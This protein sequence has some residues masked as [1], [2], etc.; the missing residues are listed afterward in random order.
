LPDHLFIAEKP[1]LAE[2]I[3]KA[4]AEQI[5]AT[6]TKT[7]GC[8]KVGDDA[9]T[10]LFGHM[11]ELAQP[12]EY[13][14]RYKTWRIDDLPIIPTKWRRTP[15][16]DKAKHLAFIRNMLKS[17]QFVVN[18]GDAE[19]EGQL[20]VDELLEEM[21]WDPF[22]DRTKRIW[23]SSMARK[24]MLAALES[25]F[26]N[27][28]KRNL[29]QAAF[30][31]QC[32]DW[33]HGLSLTRLYTVL[34]RQ[35]GADMLVTVGRVQ[36]PTLWLVV[37]RDRQIE[38]FKPTDHY[39]PN[40]LFRH[41]NGTFKAD[42]VIPP[43]HE[44]LDPDGRLVDK[45]VAERIAAKVAG[46][47]GRI[48]SFTSTPKSKAPPLPYSLSALQTDCS[49]KL[50]LTAQ[51]TL[52]VAQS[53]YERHR[54]TTYPRSDSRYLP[55]ALRDEVPGIMS[56][57]AGCDGFGE[58]ARKAN[59]SLKSAAW[60][61]SKVSD[62]HGIIPTSEFSPSK[63]AEM[64]QIERSVFEL[65]AKA[66]I[67][68]FHPDFT[69]KSLVATLTV[70]GETFRATGRQVI[71][72]GWK[73][74]YGAEE[75]DEDEDKET[76]QTLPQMAKGD[77]VV[78]ESTAIASKRTQPPAH[79]T[80]GSL[81]AAMA[82]IHKFVP[83]GEIKRR[84]KE[85]DGIGTEATRASIIEKLVAMKFL[86][87]KGKTK[88]VST[89]AGRAIIDVLPRE[90][91]DP[92]LT[93]IWEAQLTKISK[94]E[95]STDQ[96]MEVLSRTLH[97]LVEQGRQSGG[98]RIAGASID[99]LPGHGETCPVCQKGRMVTVVGRQGDLKGKRYLRC[100]NWRKDDP[101]SCRN[102][103]WPERPRPKCDPMP[104]DGTKCPT[105]GKGTLVTALSRNGS[106][107]LYCNAYRK[108]DPA[109]CRHIVWDRPKIDPMPGEG[110]SCPKC[111]SGTMVTRMSRN[112]SRFLSCSNWRKDDPN[113]CNHVV[114]DDAKPKVDPMPGD[115]QP[116]GKCG[117][118]V[119]RT[120]ATKDGRR[121]LSC[122]NWRRDDPSSCNNVVWD[123]SSPPARAGGASRGGKAGSKG[124]GSLIAKV[125]RNRK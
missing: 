46:R 79:F 74:V 53:L 66:F 17:S 99:P 92:G 18:A 13:D 63:L 122:D 56:A 27:R 5:G 26:P 115:G 89:K 65:I 100:D 30:A 119:M 62:H 20:L 59:L 25:M 14:E 49:R 55:L 88:L 114:W 6:A 94:G 68:Q 85:S 71:S 124:T 45:A 110:Q 51:Q 81:I 105:C 98:L 72:Q 40:G 42:W 121:F 80:D 102:V 73:V 1:S 2:A 83:D 112:G 108:D 77:P 86:Q 29:F 101:T 120:R 33:A 41:A 57:L 90:I 37:D 32:A 67:S 38:N 75:D 111:G 69:W 125:A 52:E 11:Y 22:G 95:A 96:F 84:L 48:E 116:C 118:G 70:A 54:A 19:R 3:A 87:R 91:I 58:A 35:T 93:A 7:E 8:W 44:G 97:K 103:V 28:D 23:V 39:L 24:D 12:H 4:R 50:G 64:S 113:S 10:W 31:R 9:V 109:S 78:A 60:N 107:F 15:H 117:K 82:N 104:G 106:R 16:K 43:E 123:N 34:A 36:T 61:D 76:E 47:E 21:G